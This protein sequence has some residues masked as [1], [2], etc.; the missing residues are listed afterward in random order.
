MAMWLQLEGM[1]VLLPGMASPQVLLVTRWSEMTG[2]SA[3]GRGLPSGG[4]PAEVKMLVTT[5]KL[6]T[7]SIC[8]TLF[9]VEC[10]STLLQGK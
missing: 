1:L 7:L 6:C 9:I 5:F 10:Q 2:V 3:P 4:T 8:G